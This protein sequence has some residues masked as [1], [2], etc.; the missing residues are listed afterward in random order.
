MYG[1]GKWSHFLFLFSDQESG[2]DDSSFKFQSLD[3]LI[4]GC[5]RVMLRVSLIWGRLP[6]MFAVVRFG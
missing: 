2:A 6:V 3:K 4:F 1:L 5:V